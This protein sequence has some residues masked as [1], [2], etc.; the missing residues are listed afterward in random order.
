MGE[1][2]MSATRILLLACGL[3]AWLAAD[4]RAQPL[5]VRGGTLI[6]GSGRPPIDDVQ[7]VIRDGVIVEVGLATAP[8]SGTATIV[9]ARGKYI[10]PG[11]IVSHIHYG[12]IER[13]KQLAAV[14]VS[15]AR[16]ETR[17]DGDA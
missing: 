7:I 9:D 10:L 16:W 5:V 1:R 12:H 2:S 13:P 15:A 3:V 11:L 6:D 4:G 8:P 14:L 17:T